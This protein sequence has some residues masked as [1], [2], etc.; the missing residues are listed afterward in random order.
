MGLREWLM[1]PQRLLLSGLFVPLVLFLLVIA[2]G[3][4]VSFRKGDRW[5]LRSAWWGIPTMAVFTSYY[6]WLLAQ[7]LSVTI[8]YV[9][10]NSA[11]YMGWLLILDSIRPGSPLMVRLFR[12]G[13]TKVV[14]SREPSQT[15]SESGESDFGGDR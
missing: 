4:V 6:G 3:L 5:L 1:E 2:A 8:C 12:A 13:G 10:G 11:L 14:D 15:G 9:L 7:S